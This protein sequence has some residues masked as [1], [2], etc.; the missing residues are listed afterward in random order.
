MQVLARLDFDPVYHDITVLQFLQ[1]NSSFLFVNNPL[2][3]LTYMI[4]S[5]LIIYE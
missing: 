5:I 3:T 2:F 1:E 4:S